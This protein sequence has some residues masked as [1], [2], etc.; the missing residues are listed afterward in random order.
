M[1]KAEVMK[2]KLIV[3]AKKNQ[4]G[5]TANLRTAEALNFK[6]GYAVSITNNSNKSL[7]KA[8]DNLITKEL[9]KF[10][11]LKKLYV[12]YWKDNKNHYIDL[13]KVI[14][15]KQEALKEAKKF[16]QLAIFDFKNLNS[17]YLK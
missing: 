10:K 5:F 8:I 12:G 3:T 6:K 9:K 1:L 11:H 14:N 16:K 4:N 7:I 13:T 2:Y 17:I 15:N